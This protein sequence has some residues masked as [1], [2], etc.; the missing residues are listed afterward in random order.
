MLNP[1]SKGDISVSFY[2]WKKTEFQDYKLPS[3]ISSKGKK[4][5]HY[6]KNL[7]SEH[8]F[9]PP[10]YSLSYMKMF[11]MACHPHPCTKCWQRWVGCT[12]PSY[13]LHNSLSLKSSVRSENL[14][15]YLNYLKSSLYKFSNMHLCVKS[16][17]LAHSTKISCRYLKDFHVKLPQIIT[18]T[19]YIW[20]E[21]NINNLYYH[22][23]KL[24]L[25][26]FKC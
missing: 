11:L 24:I 6:S 9:S 10:H 19:K 7:D 26:K 5:E 14:S 13:Q 12:L 8:I 15:I 2:R 22:L 3:T 18:L 16:Y 20:K 17:L 23:R 21:N 25:L 4:T 1:E